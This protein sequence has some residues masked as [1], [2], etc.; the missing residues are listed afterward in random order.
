[1]VSALFYGNLKT[2][3]CMIEAF[4]RETLFKMW[5]MCLIFVRCWKD[6]SDKTCYFSPRMYMDNIERGQSPSLRITPRSH[7]LRRWKIIR[8]CQSSFTS[9]AQSS[10]PVSFNELNIFFWITYILLRQFVLTKDLQSLNSLRV[11]DFHFKNLFASV[12]Y[13]H[14]SP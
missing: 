4:V 13:K 5:Q 1:M 8:R 2:A 7:C 3:S 10:P 12:S 11:S 14:P 6:R 9:K